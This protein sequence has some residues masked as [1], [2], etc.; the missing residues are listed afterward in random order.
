L[1]ALAPL[2]TAQRRGVLSRQLS[3]TA[4]AGRWLEGDDLVTLSRREERTLLPGVAGLTTRTAG[5]L[6]LGSQRLGVG[7][8]GT[9]WGRGVAWGLVEVVLQFLDLGE[10]RADDGLCFRRLAGNQLFGDLQAT[11]EAGKE[12]E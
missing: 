3:A 6:G 10:Q 11:H 7:M 5:R 8:F 4:P 12:K 1:K 9:R 2:G